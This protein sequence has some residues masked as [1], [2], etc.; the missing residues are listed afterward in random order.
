[1]S[2]A[3]NYLH[4]LD[5][6]AK[7]AQRYNRNISDITLVS[8]SKGYNWQHVQPAYDLGCRNFGENRL[9]EALEKIPEAPTDINWHMIGTLQ[10]NKVKSAI[11]AFSLIHSV[12][13]FELAQIISDMSQ[14]FGIKTPILLQVNTSDEKTKHG[15][16]GQAWS[17]KL[18]ILAGLQ[19]IQ[20][21]GLMTIAPF[22]Q[23]EVFIRRCFEKLRLLRDEFTTVI[24]MHHLSMGMSN[25]YQWAIAEG[26]TLLRIGTAIFG[27]RGPSQNS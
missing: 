7:S 16:S 15:L 9:Q 19:G 25:D 18:D 24:P 21:E 27:K 26:A 14:Q 12:D 4:V 1:M 8:V 2:V 10:K 5:E 3:D 11:Q 6:I 23:D 17:E 22:I 20:I 13:S